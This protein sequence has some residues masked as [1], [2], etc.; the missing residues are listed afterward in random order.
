MAEGVEEKEQ[1]VFLKENQ[2][3][4][5]QGYFFSRPIPANEFE[6]RFKELQVIA[7]TWM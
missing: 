3:N 2:C 5:L 1:L 6:K 7:K 4:E